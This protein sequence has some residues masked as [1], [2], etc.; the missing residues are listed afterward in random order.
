MGEF[1]TADIRGCKLCFTVM[2][3]PR[4]LV[5]IDGPWIDALVQHLLPRA[6]EAFYSQDLAESQQSPRS[7]L[8]NADNGR[9]VWK[10][11]TGSTASGWRIQYLDEKG[12]R[13]Q[14]RAGLIVPDT[15]LSG[16]RA[17]GTAWM[18]NCK[19]VLAKARKIW[20]RVD[21]S[22]DMRYTEL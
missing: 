4:I 14:T 16:E 17:T 20:D 8:K 18:N 3:G 1:V 11:S 15:T 19:H 9:V 22:G 21:A 12:Q 10:Q 6:G 13:R 7:L 5:P 2:R